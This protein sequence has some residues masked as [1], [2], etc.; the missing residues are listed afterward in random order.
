MMSECLACSI[1]RQMRLNG[2]R[3]MS[4]TEHGICTDR[5]KRAS[6]D[7]LFSTDERSRIMARIKGTGTVSEERLYEIVREVH[8]HMWKI[9][10]SGS[11][12]P[13]TPDLVAPSLKQAI[14]A[15]GC[16]F[17][18]RPVH[19]RIPKSSTEYREHRLTRTVIRDRSRRAE[20][21]GM[22]YGV[23]RVWEHDLRPTTV[24]RTTDRRRKRLDD[25]RARFGFRVPRC[26]AR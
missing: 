7:E 10:C 5:W 24:S 1:L 16:F 9:L 15:D 14:F 11:S 6:D 13:G 20:I 12:L 18:L 26:V 4:N 23:W 3:T 8:G 17:H 21:R 19:S 25:R 2:L 22:G